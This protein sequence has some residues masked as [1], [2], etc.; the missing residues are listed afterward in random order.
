MRRP[1]ATRLATPR[2]RRLAEGQVDGGPAGA[3]PPR[4]EE[5][6]R[7]D[8][9]GEPIPSEHRHLLDL[10][11]RELQCTCRACA[12]LFDRK[13]AGGGRYLRVPDRRLA[14]VDLELPDL[15]W[16]ELRIPVEMAFFFRSSKER[17]IMAYY[18][19]PMGPT[20]SLLGL[21]AWDELERANPILTTMEDDVEALL[22][23]RARGARAHWLVPIEDCYALVGLI[24]TQWRG[25]SGGKDVW[26]EI[27]R[28]FAELDGRSKRSGREI[29]GQASEAPAGV[30]ERR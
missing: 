1:S 10:E 21:E 16:E 22:V 6:E 19:S 12:L 13:A 30:A 20:E 4:A 8:L 24:R 23:N 7:C 26:T 25:F 27:E 5:V 14:L 18:P 9:C 11:T 29:E 2:L 28:F 17:R 3:N 15:V